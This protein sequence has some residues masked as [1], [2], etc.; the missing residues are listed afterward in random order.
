MDLDLAPSAN[1]G[2]SYSGHFGSD[3][4]DQSVL[5]PFSIKF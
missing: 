3:V 2:F 5:G 4:T 1:L